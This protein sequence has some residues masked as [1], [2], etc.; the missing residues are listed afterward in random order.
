M[1][2]NYFFESHLEIIFKINY[3]HGMK[4]LNFSYIGAWNFLCFGPQGI[5]IKFGDYGKVVFI[6]GENRDVKKEDEMPSDEVRVSSNGS[7]KSSIQEIIVY[8]L[9]GK[10]IKKPSAILKDGVINNIVGK[11]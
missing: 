11:D 2:Q 1:G 8:G 9:Y 7:G 3:L 10:S 4:N 6:R 5:E